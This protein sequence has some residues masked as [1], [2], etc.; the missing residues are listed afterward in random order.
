M[1]SFNPSAL[2]LLAALLSFTHALPVA[3]S[4]FIKRATSAT[5]QTTGTVEACLGVSSLAN[6]VILT[7]GVCTAGTPGFYNQWDISPGDNQ[8]IRLSGLPQGSGDWCLDAGL[9]YTSGCFDSEATGGNPSRQTWNIVEGTTPS[10]PPTQG[11]QI[12]W[13]ENGVERCLQVNNAG[14]SNGQ[15]IGINVCFTESLSFYPFQQFIYNEGSTKIRV[16]P[17]IF[18]DTQYCIDFGE[19]LGTNGQALKIW[20]CY[21]GLPQQQLYIT[22]DRH[23]AVENRPGGGQCADVKAE[24]GVEPVRPYG[25]RK[26]V[27]SWECIGGNTNQHHPS[28]ELFT[29]QFV[30]VQDNE[31]AVSRALTA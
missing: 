2:A 24:S 3:P 18:T 10:P 5:I 4:T 31:A 20:Q 14:F 28:G 29:Q 26:Q 30:T 7:S 13:L 16:A 9:D 19:N 8:V 17:N 6:G 27:Q 1:I 11:R 15:T 25:V 21:E 12:K 22:S 23:I